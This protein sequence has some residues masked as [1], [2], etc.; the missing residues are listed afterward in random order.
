[1]ASGS[2]SGAQTTSGSQTVTPTAVGAD[3]YTLTCS[4]AGGTV[5]GSA[6]LTVNAA[7]SGHHGG[8]LDITTLL[9]LSGVLLASRQFRRRVAA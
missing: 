7:S 2:W 5:N 6:T 8:A 9:A 1:M 3:T 4:D